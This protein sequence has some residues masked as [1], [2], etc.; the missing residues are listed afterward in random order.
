MGTWMTLLR[1]LSMSNKLVFPHCSATKFLNKIIKVF[2]EGKFSKAQSP[3]FF[4]HIA[5]IRLHNVFVF[6]D[7]HH[8]RSN[9]YSAINSC[10]VLVRWLAR[11]HVWPWLITAYF[12]RKFR[13]HLEGRFI[14]CQSWRHKRCVWCWEDSMGDKLFFCFVSPPDSSNLNMIDQCKG[15]HCGTC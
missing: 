7:G 14:N 13:G 4:F 9:D 15:T 8:V 5:G 3:Y 12:T 6:G 11:L 10:S 1:S 2:K